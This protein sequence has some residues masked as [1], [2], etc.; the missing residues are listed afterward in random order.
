MREYY[1]YTRWELFGEM[2]GTYH[3]TITTHLSPKEFLSNI[4]DDSF[5]GE[6]FFKQ[7]H[8]KE[9]MEKYWKS[10]VK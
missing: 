5:I 6:Y 4:C 9:E 2:A 10:L 7:F 1:Y 8:T 3:S